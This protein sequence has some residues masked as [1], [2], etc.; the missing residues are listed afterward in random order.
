[1]TQEAKLT[2]RRSE[3]ETVQQAVDYVKAGETRS[4]TLYLIQNPAQLRP[5]LEKLKTQ[6]IGAEKVM[7]DVIGLLIVD[8]AV[9]AELRAPADVETTFKLALEQGDPLPVLAY[10][11]QHPENIEQFCRYATG[12][13]AGV[14][15]MR[16]GFK[17]LFAGE[18]EE[19][20]LKRDGLNILTEVME[21]LLSNTF[22]TRRVRERITGALQDQAREEDTLRAGQA[23]AELLG[24][25]AVFGT[26]ERGLTCR[27]EFNPDGT[28]KTM[29][30]HVFLEAREGE[31][32]ADLRKA[33][34]VLEAAGIP[35]HFLEDKRVL[36]ASQKDVNIALQ[37][38]RL[39]VEKWADRDIFD[40][41]AVSKP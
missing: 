6:K 22:N 31:T 3:N 34:Q 10:L 21:H 15:M 12:L 37:E 4:A 38:G 29:L 23:R 19:A 27:A 26:G 35:L 1:M 17:R 39:T 13:K 14:T 28:V 18:R 5:F 30:T 36:V 20:K 8:Y 33:A 41:K 11:K 2:D 40:F 25:S 24:K 9:P 16:F 32:E 7:A